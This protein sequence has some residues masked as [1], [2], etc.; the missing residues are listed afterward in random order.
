MLCLS[1][2]ETVSF[3][4]IFVTA[5]CAVTVHSKRRTPNLPLYIR[6]VCV[7][8]ML[9]LSADETVSFPEILVTANC[10]VTDAETANCAAVP[11][12]EPRR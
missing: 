6:N 5:N 11:P 7:V 9:C 1:A 3:P 4:P 2:E 10:A 12:G 8:G